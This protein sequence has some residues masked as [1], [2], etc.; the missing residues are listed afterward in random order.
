[1]TEEVKACNPEK[2][3]ELKNEGNK[4]VK[5][6][7]YAKAAE[8]YTKAIEHDPENTILY[9]N[10]AFT[11]LKLDNFQSSLDD[12]KRAIELD[13]NNLKAYHRRAMSYICLLYTSRCV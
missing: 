10:R 7:L 9:S 2:A 3:L 12:A 11:N 13:N 1:M 5:E 8:Y 6:K 4:F